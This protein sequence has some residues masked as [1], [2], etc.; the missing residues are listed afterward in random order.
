MAQPAAKSSAT[1]GPSQPLRDW[2][3]QA[4]C[5]DQDPD[6]FFPV[7]G[8]SALHGRAR[9]GVVQVQIAQA[10]TVCARCPVRFECGSWAL[11]TGQD[12]GV[13][14]GFDEEER[15]VIRRR[16][17]WDTLSEERRRKLLRLRRR[18]VA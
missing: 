3:N 17:A 4:T 6:L 14:G 10:K 8:D 2:R 18:R 1:R 16:F 7:G 9:T 13:W 12:Y 5:R 11:D 15:R